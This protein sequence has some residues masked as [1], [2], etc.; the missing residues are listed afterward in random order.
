MFYIGC[1]N[2]GHQYARIVQIES[3]SGKLV[4][5]YKSIAMPLGGS[6]ND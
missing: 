5:N 6:D 3:R 2:L 4:F 1:F